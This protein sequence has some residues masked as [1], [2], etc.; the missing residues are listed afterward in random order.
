M[1]AFKDLKKTLEKVNN[2]QQENNLQQVR[3]EEL[4]MFSQ[5]SKIELD[6]VSLRLPKTITTQIKELSR[7]YDLSKTKVCE[8]LI[9]SA[10]KNIK[11]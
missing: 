7:R 4:E 5:I 2:N 8:L 9:K 10:L 1:S 3:I 6:P 11:D